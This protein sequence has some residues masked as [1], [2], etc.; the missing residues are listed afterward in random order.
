MTASRVT[1]RVHLRASRPRIEV[2]ADELHVWVTSSP[3]AGAA[4]D[5]VIRAVASWAHCKP[6]DARIVSGERQR[7]K[8]VEI[9]ELDASRLRTLQ[10]G[11]HNAAD[12]Q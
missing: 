4:N 10:S 12:I 1:V 3:V 2:Q 8:V 9:P 11:Q 5:E 6:S 7:R